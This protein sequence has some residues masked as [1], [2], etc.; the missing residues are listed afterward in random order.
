MKTPWQFFPRL[1]KNCVKYGNYV[2]SYWWCQY[3]HSNNAM[4][5]CVLQFLFVFFFIYKSDD[6]AQVIYG[7]GENTITF[8]EI[9]YPENFLFL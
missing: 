4:T 5:D 1:E 6:I 3:L 2:I 7:N 8:I 9:Y